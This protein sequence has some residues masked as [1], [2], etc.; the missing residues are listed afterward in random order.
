MSAAPV[1]VHPGRQALADAS[2]ARLVVALLDA[3]AERDRAHVSMTGGSM[4]SQIVRSLAAEPARD[5][6]DWGRVHVWWGDERYL[7]AGD[8]DRNDT[9]NDEAGLASLGLPPGNVHRVP[10]P[11]LTA[12]AEDAAEAYAAALE[13]HAVDLFDVMVLGVGPDGHVASLFPHHPAA[14]TAGRPTVAVH[15]SP[16]PPPDRVSLTRE[17]LERSREVWFLVAGGDKADAVRRG[18]QGSSFAETPAANVHGEQRTLWLLD[19]DAAA[20][21]G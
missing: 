14:P 4:G 10:G 9:Q 17:R 18:V 8:P 6:V 2:A 20:D 11:D 15:D 19:A 7:P 12:S 21:L 3:L 16:K 1:L 13:E 5:A